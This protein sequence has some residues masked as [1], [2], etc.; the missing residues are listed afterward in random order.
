MKELNKEW[1]DV[2][3]CA[4]SQVHSQIIKH[5]GYSFVKIITEIQLFIS[6]KCKI[7]IH[8]LSTQLK[9]LIDEQIFSL[10]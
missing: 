3:F 4:I 2:L 7:Q 1:E 8:S 10:V 5:L 9:V 6:V